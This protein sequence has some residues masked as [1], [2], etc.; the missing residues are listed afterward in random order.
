MTVRSLLVACGVALLLRP[1]GA[2]AHDALQRSVPAKDAHL[3]VAPTSLRLTFSSA[4][5]L[6]FVRVSLVAGGT[7]VR[8]GAPRLDSARTV[9]VN[10]LGTL[11]PGPYTV[12]WQIAGRDGHP[13][14]GQ[15]S[16]TIVPGATGALAGTPDTAA[17]AATHHD[18][19]AMP[20]G[21]GF[22]AQ[23]PAY[24]AVRW[25]SL[26]SIVALVGAVAFRFMVLML[27]ARRTGSGFAAFEAAALSRA[28]RLGIG[29]AAALLLAT[30]FRL[31]A[32][33]YALHGGARALDPGLLRGLLASTTWGR[34]WIWQVGAAGTALVGLWLARRVPRAWAL[35]ALAALL[36]AF[37][38]PLS[39]HAIA[40]QNAPYIVALDGLHV[41]GASGWI[42]GL[43]ALMTAGVPAAMALGARERGQAV[44][45]LVHAF[46]PTALAFAGVTA[47]SGALLALT[48]LGSL[49]ALGAS[50]YGRALLIKLGVLTV[51]ALTGAYNWLRVRPA[52]GD[53]LGARRLRTSASMELAVSVVVIAI[54]AVLVATPP[55]ATMVATN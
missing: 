24:V 30:L 52:L 23:S 53:D 46:S 10:I 28:A 17:G 38:A 41:L 33:S 47:L 51:V 4:P 3:A 20:T 37:T 12:V 43:L 1:S 39:G 21:G 14:R 19:V 45:N 8:L 36:V 25:V 31:G 11:R 13:V 22:D 9:V 16:F 5:H 7:A 54:T 26:S 27:G 35:A 34:A 48:H 29:A 18:P 49:G 44:A 50:E 32:Q 6:A 42:G 40:A 55:P 2:W 15:Y